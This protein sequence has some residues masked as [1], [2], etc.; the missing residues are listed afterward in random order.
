MF[1]CLRF[2]ALYF[3]F[4]NE[5]KFYNRRAWTGHNHRP[6]HDTMRKRHRTQTATTG[7]KLS[8]QP[9]LSQQE[10]IQSVCT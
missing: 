4:E 1:G 9:C 10:M 8:K 2:I 6:T 7:L 5:L 3:E